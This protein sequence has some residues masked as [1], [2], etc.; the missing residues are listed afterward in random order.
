M[1]ARKEKTGEKQAKWFPAHVRAEFRCGELSGRGRLV[2]LSTSGALLEE[3]DRQPPTG[4]SLS[5]LLYLVSSTEPLKVSAEIVRHTETGGFEA[6]FSKLNARTS[7]GLRT[8]LPRL[9]KIAE[10]PDRR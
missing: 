1:N 9:K 4:Q 2:Q 6:T 10:K 3:V 7:Q 8:L 5:L